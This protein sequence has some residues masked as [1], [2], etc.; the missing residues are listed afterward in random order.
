MQHGQIRMNPVSMAYSRIPLMARK[1]YF[2]KLA[3]APG[4]NNLATSTG[5]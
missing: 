3:T 2:G 4:V 5:Q 1:R